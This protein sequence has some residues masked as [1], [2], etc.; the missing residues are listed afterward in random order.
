M[1]MFCFNMIFKHFEINQHAGFMRKVN[2]DWSEV[3]RSK[4]GKHTLLCNL[5]IQNIHRP[6]RWNVSKFD[7]LRHFGW[8][9]L[10]EHFPLLDEF[11]YTC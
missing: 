6:S 7:V 9:F 10:H 4:F 2:V 8:E 3:D 11:E 1:D 5:K